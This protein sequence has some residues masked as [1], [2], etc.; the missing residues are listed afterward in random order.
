MRIS[1]TSFLNFEGFFMKKMARILSFVIVTSFVSNTY[2][3]SQATAYVLTG[4]S[5]I[6]ATGLTYLNQGD[7]YVWAWGAGGIFA[8][9]LIYWLTN[10]ITP[11]GRLGRAKS[12]VEKIR[13]N[14]L[15]LKPFESE[16]QLM[17]HLQ[18][19]YVTHDLPLVTAF[20]DLSNLYQESI[21][22]VG[23]LNA[24][25]T[26][27]HEYDFVQNCQRL[28]TEAGAMRDNLTKVIKMVRG[29]KEYLEQVKLADQ[30]NFARQQIAVQQ[31][32]AS[33]KWA[34]VWQRR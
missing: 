3:I 27:C 28:I 24:A 5:G 13:N 7:D 33:A 32:M 23:L 1:T 29:N 9:G 6:T 20:N 14:S 26:D 4:A 16:E 34:S 2:P 22:A 10:R 17:N 8:T 19:V 11:H 18:E 30:R 21:N 31:D 25:M 12:K 15:A